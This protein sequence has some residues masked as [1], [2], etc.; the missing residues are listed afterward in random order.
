MRSEG[1]SFNS[2]GRKTVE[3]RDKVNPA[4]KVRH[5]SDSVLELMPALRASISNTRSIH[6]LPAAAIE[7]RA[8]G[9]HL[10]RR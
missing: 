1:P 7:C 3:F 10:R 6:G 2:H 4:P 9:A 8:F 5:N